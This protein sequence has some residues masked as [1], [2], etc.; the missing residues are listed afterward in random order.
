MDTARVL[1][2]P[3]ND[4]LYGST[5]R[6]PSP[7]RLPAKGLP[8][9]IDAFRT[10]RYQDCIALLSPLLARTANDARVV[11]MAAQCHA[12]LGNS[13]QAANFYARAADLDPQNARM[14]RL[15][16]ARSYKRAGCRADALVLARQA[17]RGGP[18]DI[19]SQ[20]NLPQ[21]AARAVVPRRMRGLGCPSAGAN[22]IR[23]C[24]CLRR[25]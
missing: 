23:G 15:L 14:L 20:K 12:K 11:L 18:F 17:A 3:S 25:R 5:A 10:G 6:M 24:R 4:R 13:E 7:K 1:G 22:E 16:A 21:P 19:E 8:D 2:S 9:A